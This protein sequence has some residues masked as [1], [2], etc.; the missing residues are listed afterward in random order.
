MKTLTDITDL[1]AQWYSGALDPSQGMVMFG[2]LSQQAAYYLSS[3]ST[4]TDLRPQLVID[5]VP[6]P[7]TIG[8]LVFGGAALIRR[9]RA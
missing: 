7:A 6:E 2:D 5:Y 4:S 1:M 9:R 3:E 8:L